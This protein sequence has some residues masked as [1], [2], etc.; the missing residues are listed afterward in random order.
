MEE[1]NKEVM[2]NTMTEVVEEATGK[3]TFGENLA[4]YGLAA[5]FSIGV[6]TTGYLGYK[7]VKALVGKIKSKKQLS[8][9]S[10]EETVEVEDTDIH[11]VE[12][13]ESEE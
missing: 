10:E 3:L 5:V 13:N 6:V 11:E 4:A 7:G 8:E 2:E 9:E 12:D 1:M